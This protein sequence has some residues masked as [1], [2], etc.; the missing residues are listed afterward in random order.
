MAALRSVRK[1]GKQ[2]QVIIGGIDGMQ[3][4]CVAVERGELVATAINPTGRIHGGAIWI[5][6][7]LATRGKLESVP[8][9]IRMDVGSSI[10]RRRGILL[11]G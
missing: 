3:P 2:D 1:A 4:A 9:F 5:G 10:A 7:F 8:K 11:V 6:Y